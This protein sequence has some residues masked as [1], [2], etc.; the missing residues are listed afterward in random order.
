[1]KKLNSKMFAKQNVVEK[2]EMSR[3]YGGGLCS[4]AS[5]VFYVDTVND[6]S[7]NFDVAYNSLIDIVE[8]SRGSDKSHQEEGSIRLNLFDFTSL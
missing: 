3:M 7:K 8:T 1:M 2:V 4:N 5:D 6:S